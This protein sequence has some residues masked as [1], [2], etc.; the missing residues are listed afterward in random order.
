[1]A[2]AEDA[3]DRLQGQD[4]DLAILDIRLPGMSGLD[5]LAQI[6]RLCPRLP[7]IVMTGQGTT[8]TAIEATKR[9]A[10]EYQLKPFDPAEM[11]ATIDKALEGARLMKGRLDLGP[12]AAAE[13][14]EAIVG[15]SAAHAAGLQGDRP[16]RP[17]R[18]HRLDPRRIRH[19]QGAGRPRHLPAQPAG[20]NAAVRSSTAPPSPRP[21]WRAS[22]SATSPGRSPAR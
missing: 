16:R 12:D 13:S 17:D 9:G 8:G 22:C 14:P 1:M 2:D 3:I 7:V 10:F 6:K 21:S 20:R 11:L 4:C 19:R 18:R 5:A 15:R